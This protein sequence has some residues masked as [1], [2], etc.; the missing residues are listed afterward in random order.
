MTSATLSQRV[1]AGDPRAMARAITLIEDESPA[2][3]D[4]VR[5]VFSHTGRA[6]LVGVTGSP[7]AGK[8]TLVDRLIAELRRAEKTVGVIAVDPTSP[9]TG[10]GF[11]FDERHGACDR[12]RIA[13]EHA[14][15]QAHQLGFAVAA[16]AGGC[17]NWRAITRR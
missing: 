10:G 4:L 8:S 1:L 11:V 15:G 12:P 7:G 9:F 17:I 13:R 2:G 6:Y 14:V 3:A 16:G 5:A